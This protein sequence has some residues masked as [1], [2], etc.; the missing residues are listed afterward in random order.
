[1]TITQNSSAPLV[2]VVGATGTQGGSVIRALEESD[3][4]YRIRGFTRDATKP[5]AQQ[6]VA[7]GVEIVAIQLVVANKE[8][9]FK[10]FAGANM[11]F[12]VTNFWEHITL[13]KEVSEAKMFIDAVEA[14]AV[15]RVVWSGLT[16]VSKAS[17]GKYTHVIP[18][19]GKAEIAEYG[20]QSGVPFVDVQAGFYASNFLD[21]PMMLA[22]QDDGSFTIELPTKPTTVVPIIDTA[23]DYGL[24]VRQVL[25]LPVFPDGSENISVEDIALQFS[26]T[27]GKK[28]VFKQITPAEF[29]NVV[30]KLECFGAFDEFGYYGGKATTSHDGLARKPRTWA[31]FIATADW[32][33]ALA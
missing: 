29:G 31:E 3:K 9:V 26:Q 28:I 10:A 17:A 23:Q 1:M 16:S 14:A 19:D 7:K 21:S 25:E 15:E 32:S 4:P 2:A 18:F 12:L 33:K 8:G 30:A 13:E 5:A 11:A 22:K 20:R 27:T 6:L 24:Y